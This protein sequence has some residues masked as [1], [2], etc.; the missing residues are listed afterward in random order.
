MSFQ[1][2]LFDSIL[3]VHQYLIQRW[4]RSTNLKNLILII[5]GNNFSCWSRTISGDYPICHENYFFFFLH[6]LI[7]LL[8][9]KSKQFYLNLKRNPFLS[10]FSDLLHVV[11]WRK[12]LLPMSKQMTTCHV[13][14]WRKMKAHLTFRFIYRTSCK[15]HWHI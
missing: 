6:T 3:N 5:L 4:N 9:N 2:T 1:L 15:N 12:W 13:I 10:H 8:K 14:C 11:W 7:E